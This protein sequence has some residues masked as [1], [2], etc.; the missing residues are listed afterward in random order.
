MK[1]GEVQQVPSPLF[2]M[3]NFFYMIFP[4][5]IC[6]DITTG[7]ITVQAAEQCWN[8][9]VRIQSG[10]FPKGRIFDLCTVSAFYKGAFSRNSSPK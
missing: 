2:Y 5:I 6:Y 10:F 8:K 7:K 3:R 4:A 9:L 1:S